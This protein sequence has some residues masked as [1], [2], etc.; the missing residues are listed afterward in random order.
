MI[1]IIDGTDD[2]IDIEQMLNYIN[3]NIIIKNL[4][5]QDL[6]DEKKLILNYMENN[7]TNL[8]KYA[9]INLYHELD[10]EVIK[11]NLIDIIKF[12]TKKIIKK[13]TYW[14]MR[15]L[16]QQQNKFNQ[17]VIMTLENQLD[18]IKILYDLNDSN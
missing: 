1:N 18:L 6:R 10:N 15:H 12:K 5:K 11:R 13:I 3:G 16:E 7:I 14:Y 9:L 2:M 17:Q 4:K 8:K